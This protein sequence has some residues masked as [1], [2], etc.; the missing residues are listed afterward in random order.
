MSNLQTK[1]QAKE[2]AITD[3]ADEV[4]ALKKEARLTKDSKTTK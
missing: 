1:I 2:D 3:T 4:K